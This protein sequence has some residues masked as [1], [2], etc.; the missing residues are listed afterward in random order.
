MK[1]IKKAKKHYKK[2]KKILKVTN[3]KNLLFVFLILILFIFKKDYFLFIGLTAFSAI[4]SFY[5]SKYN[6]TPIDFKLALVLGIFIT[7]YYN[8]LFTF[9]FFIVSDLVPA[10][11][12]GDSLRGAD[13]IFISWYFIINSL[14]LLF[15]STSLA[16]LGPILVIVEAIG[17]FFI[18][19]YF[20]IPGFMSIIISGIVSIVRVTYFLTLGRLL[21]LL[22]QII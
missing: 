17:S 10:L 15:P 13:L 4:F 21:E 19:N 18:N 3:T 12:G 11:L 1:F 9:I 6:R 2:Q 14:V 20:G 7:R 8:L 5:H 16:I 22:F